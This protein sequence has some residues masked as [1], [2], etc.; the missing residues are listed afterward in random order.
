MLDYIETLFKA[1]NE[2]RQKEII[3]YVRLDGRLSMGS[4]QPLIDRFND[5]SSQIHVFLSSTRAGSLGINLVGANRV[6]LMDVCWNPIH[7]EQAVVRIFRYGQTKPVYIYRLQAFGTFE[8]K[9][10]QNNIRKGILSK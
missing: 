3:S 2:E 8:D 7:D 5:P 1:I 4:R 6:I 9:M 10:Y